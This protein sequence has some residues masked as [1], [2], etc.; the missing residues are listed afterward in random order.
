MT[1]QKTTIPYEDEDTG[2]V[3]NTYG[4]LISLLIKDFPV[5]I[6]GT[7]SKDELKDCVLE[8]VGSLYDKAWDEC[9]N[10]KD[11]RYVYQCGM[12]S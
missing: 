10:N 7:K 5:T 4:Y 2:E 1:I 3:I 12:V 6:T 9:K 11:G 8:T